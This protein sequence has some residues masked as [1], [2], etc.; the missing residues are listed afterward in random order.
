MPHFAHTTAERED[1]DQLAIELV[2]GDYHHI[3]LFFIS[4]I[5]TPTKSH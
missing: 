4:G 3:A 5:T 2:P 1:G